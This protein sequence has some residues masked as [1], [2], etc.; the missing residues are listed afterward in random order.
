LNEDHEVEI[1]EGAA[2]EAPKRPSA[3]RRWLLLTAKVALAA[4][5]I[6]YVASRQSWGE[7]AESLRRIT[8]FALV[9]AT[10]AQFLSLVLATWRWR[11]LMRAYGAS[12]FP[13]YRTML[14]VYLVAYFYNTFVPGAVGGDVLRG[15]VMRRS[16]ERGATTASLAIVLIERALGLLGALVVVTLSAFAAAPGEP[17]RK[18]LFIAPLV[19]CGV[20]SAIFALTHGHRLA[21]YV[22]IARISALLR[23]LPTLTKP[24][25]FGLSVTV[26]IVVQLMFV[27]CGHVLMTAAHPGTRW[28]D[29]LFVMPC[30]AVATF[31]PL[32]VL[33][34]GPRDVAFVGLFTLSGVPRAA[35][36]A[37]S[38]AVFVVSLLVAGTGGLLHL[39]A[40]L[41]IPEPPRPDP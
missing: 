21:P 38:A 37:G 7:L 36:L 18:L 3:R 24:G 32:S 10:G 25:Y 20:L 40:P 35:A 8:P 33:G 41:S 11:A 16:F 13:R 31:I 27:V 39:R 5:L 14:R 28:L 30:A 9:A 34:A 22:P 6:I 23:D 29:S 1:T 19:L 26:S 2:L 17:P 15:V 12:Y 4:I